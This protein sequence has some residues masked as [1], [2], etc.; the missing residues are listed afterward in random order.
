MYWARGEFAEWDLGMRQYMSEQ[1]FARWLSILE[2]PQPPVRDNNH[3]DPFK[4]VRYL[5]NSLC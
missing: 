1:N 5:M 2:C 4:P 3:Q